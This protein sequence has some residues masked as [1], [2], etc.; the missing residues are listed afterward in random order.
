MSVCS[1][2]SQG[3]PC[4]CANFLCSLSSLCT[5]Q[6][7]HLQARAAREEVQDA[8][9]RLLRGRPQWQHTSYINK[10]KFQR[11]V[12][13][14]L[15]ENV[16]TPEQ[17][18]RRDFRSST[19]SYRF[20]LHRDAAFTRVSEQLW[21]AC[22]VTQEGQTVCSLQQSCWGWQLH[23]AHHQPGGTWRPSGLLCACLRGA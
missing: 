14:W 9:C 12:S 11:P 19:T 23:R 8:Q 21:G 5:Y 3:G 6:A 17:L 4:E 22:D 18:S 10:H 2:S 15:L 20:Q 16:V 13:D 1:R 7:C